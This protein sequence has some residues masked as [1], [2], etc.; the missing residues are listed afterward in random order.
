MSRKQPTSQTRSSRCGANARPGDKNT[1]AVLYRQH[2]HREKL[3]EEL[4]ARDIPFI[5]IGMNV[6][7]TGPVR[8]L[9]ALARAV[10]NPGDGEGLFRVCTFAKFDIAAEELREKLASGG[11]QKSL[12]GVL[13]TMESG[14]CGTG[15]GEAGARICA[16]RETAAAAALKFLAREF[17]LA[18]EEPALQAVLRF[19]DTWEKKPFLESGSL[20]EFLDYLKYFDQAGGVIPLYTEEQMDELQREYPDAVQLMSVHAAKG[21]EFTHVWLMRVTSNSFPSS[22]KETLFEFPAALRGSIAVGEGKEVHEQEERRLFYVAITRARDQLRIA[23]RAGRGKDKTPAGYMR[24]LLLDPTLKGILATRMVSAQPALRRVSI[25]RSWNRGCGC[26]RH[27]TPTSWRSA[28]MLSRTIP[29]V[30]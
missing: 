17:G 14:R 5:V 11:S 28:R 1:L 24:P 12:R 21:L 6:M 20:Q 23:T 3:M 25:C 4:S 22:Y 10:A 9:L 26:L 16:G 15:S 19:A 18:Y 27:L 13:Q 2:I 29:P 8:D 7:E 30:R